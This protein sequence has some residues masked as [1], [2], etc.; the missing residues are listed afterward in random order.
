M[1]I[2]LSRD[3][4]LTIAERKNLVGVLAEYGFRPVNENPLIPFY[5]KGKDIVSV[6][7]NG[8][9]E[10]LRGERLSLA[11]SIFDLLEMSSFEYRGRDANGVI[12]GVAV[13]L[14]R[15]IL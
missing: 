1:T 2:H 13:T 4:P 9:A 6:S 3:V 15:A 7:W 10:S 14:E 8:V 5:M 11:N 12:E